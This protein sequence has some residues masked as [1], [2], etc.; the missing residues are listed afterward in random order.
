MPNFETE[1][2][3]AA[4]LVGLGFADSHAAALAAEQANRGIPHL[5]TASFMAIVRTFLYSETDLS[6]IAKLKETEGE[7]FGND[8]TLTAMRTLIQSGA[9]PADVLCIAREC[10]LKLLRQLFI[11]IDNVTNYSGFP[12]TGYGLYAFDAETEEDE[13]HLDGLSENFHQLVD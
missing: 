5:E 1:N 12:V 3:L 4:K 9:S 13:I 6:K 8:A 11:L 2:E 7:S 10:Q